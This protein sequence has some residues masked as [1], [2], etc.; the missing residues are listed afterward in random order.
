MEPVTVAL[1][2]VRTTKNT[3]RYEA[4]SDEV[5]MSPVYISK[6]PARRRAPGHNPDPGAP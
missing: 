5:I 1:T 6:G 3:F 2:L 4:D